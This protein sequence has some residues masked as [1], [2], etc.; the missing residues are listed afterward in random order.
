M[1]GLNLLSC[2]NADPN[3]SATVEEVVAENSLFV[4]AY[5]RANANLWNKRQK[6]LLEKFSE[7]IAVLS[8][9]GPQKT[10]DDTLCDGN[11]MSNVDEKNT[12]KSTVSQMDVDEEKFDDGIIRSKLRVEGCSY[13]LPPDNSTPVL[14]KTA[15]WKD[16][17][18]KKDETDKVIVEDA[19]SD[20]EDSA[21]N[22]KSLKRKNRTTFADYNINR[23]K[24]LEAKEDVSLPQEWL[25][26]LTC[27]CQVSS[28]ILGENRSFRLFAT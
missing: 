13:S 5:G 27:I 8:T 4:P 12:I 9:F 28:A 26:L 2:L 24:V 19:S 6:G 22:K 20:D 17:V 14:L 1:D 16:N 18:P 3:F 7:D 23:R 15:K 21:K 11:T 10:S 25:T